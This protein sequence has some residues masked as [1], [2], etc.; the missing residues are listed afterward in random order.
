MICGSVV[1]HLKL[2]VSDVL[3][4]I[5][6][7]WGFPELLKQGYPQS[8]SM[9][10]LFS[11]INHPFGGTT[12]LWKPPYRGMQWFAM[13]CNGQSVNMFFCP[14]IFWNLLRKSSDLPK[15]LMSILPIYFRLG[16]LDMLS[17][18][19]HPLITDPGIKGPMVFRAVAGPSCV[20]RRSSSI[21]VYV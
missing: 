3:Y 12:I 17:S 16:I 10:M 15:K 18:D 7:K 11:I 14:A 20:E 5:G 4:S 13:A 21:H 8:S 2:P 9:F 19:V 6:A 1:L